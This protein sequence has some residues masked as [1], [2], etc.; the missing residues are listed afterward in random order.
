MTSLTSLTS[1]S[2]PRAL[3]ATAAVVAIAL[4]LAGL[5]ASLADAATAPTSARAAQE[6]RVTPSAFDRG[7]D[8]DV[9]LVLDGKVV[10]GD[11]TIPVPGNATELVAHDADGYVVLTI[12]DDRDHLVRVADGQDPV[13]LR[14]LP[15]PAEVA[16]A[17]DGSTVFTSVYRTG[18][19]RSTIAAFDAGTG[20]VVA[21][22]TFD[23]YAY[24]LDGNPDLV[25][26]SASKGTRTLEWTLEGNTVRTI[27]S[28]QGYYADLAT[29]T[30]AAFTGDPYDGGCTR[31]SAVDR[32]GSTLWRDCDAAVISSAPGG[33]TVTVFILS[34]GPGPSEMTV[35]TPDGHPVTTY[36][37]PRGTVG[38][39]GWEPGGSVLL[40]VHGPK[41]GA[42]VRCDD[43]D[44]E[45]A[46][47][48]LAGT[49]W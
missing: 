27:S 38:V 2:P 37:N 20:D 25:L 12:I 35:R 40:G 34:D 26:V 3:A 18:T 23:R 43:A 42:I 44:C 8:A 48:Y 16:V 45:R 7:R 28:D 30:L 13:D 39:A 33:R 41:R 19:K 17:S 11:T 9:P 15:Y 1:L 32:P 47:A 29:N 5:T 31:V 21:R 24:A 10:D 46:S 22:R 4:P 49:D 36:N 6:V 14:T